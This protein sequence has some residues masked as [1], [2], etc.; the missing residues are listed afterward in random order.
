MNASYL[1]EN[2]NGLFDFT[3]S[4]T[5]CKCFA[6]LSCSICLLRLVVAKTITYC[7]PLVMFLG[8]CTGA[9]VLS[10]VRS[11]CWVTGSASRHGNA[12]ASRRWKY[13][14]NF[15]LSPFFFFY[16][17]KQRLTFFPPS[18][19]KMQDRRAPSDASTV[20]QTSASIASGSASRTFGKVPLTCSRNRKSV[21]PRWSAAPR[22]PAWCCFDWRSESAEI[23]FQKNK[24][25]SLSMWR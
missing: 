9:E 15:F 5:D 13:L 4:K 11:G 3:F 10:S 1:T 19:F 22:A 7:L 24:K 6:R 18:E 23:S 14:T 16:W 21:S 8:P 2:L 20:F 17:S 12:N 25:I